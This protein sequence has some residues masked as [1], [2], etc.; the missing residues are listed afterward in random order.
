MPINDHI[1]IAIRTNAGVNGC[2]ILIA[3]EEERLEEKLH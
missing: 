1:T 2:N 3:L